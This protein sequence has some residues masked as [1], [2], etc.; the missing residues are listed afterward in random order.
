MRKHGMWRTFFSIY[1]MWRMH[2]VFDERT[3]N[4][5]LQHEGEYAG[6]TLRSTFPYMEIQDEEVIYA[7]VHPHCRCYLQRVPNPEDPR[8]EEGYLAI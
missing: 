1:D 7:K 8:Y 3:C 5:C 2:M 6:N 4:V